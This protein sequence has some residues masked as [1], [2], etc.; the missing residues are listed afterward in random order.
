MANS[1]DKFRKGVAQWSGNIGSAGISDAVVKTVPLASTSGLPTDTAVM[2]TVNRVD[3]NG[4]KTGNYEG[5][6]GVVSGSNL[7]DCIRGVEGTAQ[8]WTGGTVVEVL[9]T[10]SNINELIDGILAEHNQDG[11]HKDTLV[12]SLK[13]TGAEINTGTEDAKIVTPKAIADSWIN[14]GYNSLSRQAIINGNFDVWQRG[15]SFSITDSTDI[16]SSDRFLEYHRAGSGGTLPTLT[17]TR[18]S[19]TAGDLYN[20]FY[21]SRLTTNGAGTTLGTNALANI[22]QRIEFGTR[23]L[24]GDGKKV[25]LSFWARSSIANKKLGVS[26]NQTYGTGGSPSASETISGTNWTL[27][28]TWTKY[29]YTFTTNTL[30]G[31]TF[32][33]ANNDYLEIYFFYMW[34]DQYKAN[35]GAASAETYVGS[36]NID[37]AQVQLCAGDVALPFMPKSYEDELRACQRYARPFPSVVVGQAW[38]TSGAYY[39]FS[40]G[41]QMRATPTFSAGQYQTSTAASTAANATLDVTSM[42]GNTIRFDT[43][44]VAGSPLTAGHATMLTPPAGAMLEAEL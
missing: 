32:G 21:Y 23:L 5:I 7:I 11:T 27:T 34:A 18:E 1:L 19:L 22:K 14:N 10:A 39:S 12:T 29:T 35:V 36:G 44:A 40:T 24:C 41:I 30:V 28:S 33:T 31:K 9:H 20:S 25:T 15:T 38:S 43:T 8:A 6:V 37:I 3:T 42:V 4:K 13:A 17:R 26:L 2:I 16:F